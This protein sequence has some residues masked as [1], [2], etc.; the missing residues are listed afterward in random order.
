MFTPYFMKNTRTGTDPCPGIFALGSIEEEE[1]LS[2]FNCGAGLMIVTGREDAA[3]VINKV[4]RYYD[5]SLHDLFDKSLSVH[6]IQLD[7]RHLIHKHPDKRIA[8]RMQTIGSDRK[9]RIPFLYC[10]TV[11]N[12]FP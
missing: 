6:F 10:R 7:L 9:Y 1:M 2:T 4:K 3:D 12:R 5:C 11:N 8:V